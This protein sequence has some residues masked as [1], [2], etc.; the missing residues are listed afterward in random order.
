MSRSKDTKRRGDQDCGK[1]GSG[2]RPI[3]THHVLTVKQ[4]LCDVFSLFEGRVAGVR[5]DAPSHPPYALDVNLKDS[6]VVRIPSPE[7]SGERPTF[8]RHFHA[9]ERFWSYAYC[10]DL[11]LDC[12]QF[13]TASGAF[14]WPG[15]K[16]ASK[17]KARLDG[18]VAARPEAAYERRHV[19]L[20]ELTRSRL[21][22]DEAY[23]PISGLNG[24]QMGAVRS[25]D[26]RHASPVPPVVY[27]RYDDSIRADFGSERHSADSELIASI[28]PA[29]GRLFTHRIS[30]AKHVPLAFPP[31]GAG[32]SRGRQLAAPCSAVTPVRE[33][34]Y[35]PTKPGLQGVYDSVMLPTIG[36]VDSRRHAQFNIAN[37]SLAVWRLASF[38]VNV[39]TVPSRPQRI[40]FHLLVHSCL[41]ASCPI[42]E[43]V[44]SPV[45]RPRA[46]RKNPERLRFWARAVVEIPS[47]RQA[48]R[49]RHGGGM[50]V[51][52]EQCT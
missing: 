29:C 39:V 34:R 6:P 28:L 10:H 43:T 7:M 42:V 1:S 32:R 37:D 15:A 52:T 14:S 46:G 23:A 8:D 9:V 11:N 25:K 12:A 26:I 4:L 48:V 21:C 51:R 24:L 30:C 18:S 44:H 36:M 20:S 38:H 19:G 2:M 49:L 13:D 35:R 17:S 33:L 40:E 22:C 45:N 41:P 16:M 50:L 5:I 27:R 31:C 3:S 47:Q